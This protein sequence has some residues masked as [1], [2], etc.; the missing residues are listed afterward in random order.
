M[1]P[2]EHTAALTQD[3][4]FLCLIPLPPTMRENHYLIMTGGFDITHPTPAYI[5]KCLDK[6]EK[7]RPA[8][9][10]K[11]SKP[12]KPP[13]KRGTASQIKAER[14]AM[15]V[16]LREG[17]TNN[18][19]MYDKLIADGYFTRANGSVVVFRTFLPEIGK[20][21]KKI[22]RPKT[23]T[24]GS[25]VDMLVKKNHTYAQIKKETGLNSEQM[26]NAFHR[27]RIS[28][29]SYKRGELVYFE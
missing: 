5:N 24:I 22:N 27:L 4:R 16:M 28:M 11:P 21:R 25:R 18:R 1:K 14:N 2:N 9:K 7:E 6:I 3:E 20:I 29:F 26:V 15:I 8:A 17:C 13:S 19:E 23:P 10:V 12:H